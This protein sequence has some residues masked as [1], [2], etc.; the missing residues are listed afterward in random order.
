V[1]LYFNQSGNGWSAA[2]TL[3]CFPHTDNLSA[4]TAVDLLGNGTACLVWSSPL[5]GD[6]RQPMRYIDLM[7]GQKPHLLVKSINNL[8]A[9]TIVQY[10]PSTKFHLDDKRK[11][12]PW[13]TKIPFPVH[14]VERVEIYDWIS[15]NRFVTRY[16]YHHGYYDG[17]EREFRGFGMVEQWDTEELGV[18]TESGELPPTTNEEPA[19]H[20]PPVLTKTWFHTGAY[21]GG[22]RISK[23]FEHEYY[24]EGDPSRSEGLLSDEQLEAMLLEDTI[25]P[26]VILSPDEL[27]EACR[28]L[29][30]SIL[31]QEIYALDRQLD[32]S[33]TEE[34]D[35]PYS[36][37]E[38][39]YTIKRV[40]PQVS[41][42]H[43]V[44]F[45]H[46]RETID[47]LYERKL[48]P[49]L[50]GKVVD[51]ATAADNSDVKR[52]ADPRV[53]HSFTL[54]V[55]KYGNV[56]Q[57]MAVGYGRRYDDAALD[58]EDRAKQKKTLITY[59]ENQYTNAIG[60]KTEEQDVHRTPLP[61]E[62]RTFELVNVTPLSGPAGITKLFRFDELQPLVNGEQFSRGDWD[63][64]YQDVNHTQATEDHAYRRL[65]E[66]VRTLYRRN[67]L[68]GAL[69]LKEVESLA[70]PYESYKLGFTPGLLDQV[71]VRGGQKLLPANA[72]EVLNVEGAVADRG[73]YVDLEGNGLWWVPSGRIFYSH[74]PDDSPS[75]ELAHAQEH[76]FLPHRYRDPFHTN[77]VSTESFVSYDA[78]D[79]LVE[80]TR[81]ALDNQ[82]T[83]GQRQWVLADGTVVPGKGGNDYRVLQPMRV[84]DPNGNC[85][86]VAF[87]ALG[88]V[89]G[90]AVMGK[91]EQNPDERQGDSF[92][93]ESF[94]AD[95]T[96][97]QIHT[98]LAVEDPH[99]LAP[100]LL[101]GATTRII[102]DLDRFRTAKQPVYAATLARETHMSDQ[103]PPDG[104][105]IQISFSYSDGFG[106]EI[107]KKIQA[108]PGPLDLDDPTSPIVAPRWVGSGWTIYN[109]KGKPVQK[110]EPFFDDTLDFKFGKKV[111]VSSTLFYDP[112]E[113]V[114]A[115]LH[116]NDT[117]EKVIFDPWRQTT[118]DANDTVA[119]HGK[120]TGDP[121]T[122][123]DIQGYVVEYFKIQPAT[124][125]TWYQACIAGTKGTEEQ[126]AAQKA[127]KHANTPTV[128]HFDTLGRTFL[129]IAHNRFDREMPGGSVE[130]ADE[131][132]PTRV[133]LDIEG[134]QRTITDALGHIVMRYDYDMLGNR[135]HQVSVDAGARWMLNDVAGNPI[136]AWDSRD[137]SF[138]TEYDPLHR[139][140]RYFV[141]GADPENP[142][143]ELL[144]E[145]LVYGEQHPEAELRNLR[146]KLYVHLDQ[147]GSVTT[148]AHD[149][150]GNLLEASRRL[151]N[152][153]QYRQVVDW[154]PVDA[155][156]VALP[157]DAK[158]LL[159]PAALEAALAPRLEADAYT[160]RT[161]Y[162]ALNR[163]VTLIMPDNTVIRHAY[164]E[165]NLL[166]RVEASLH[167]ATAATPFVTD[168]AYDAKGQSQRIDYGNGVSTF[169]EYDP[170]TFRLVHL[171]TRRNAANFPDDC[172]QSPPAGWPGCQVQNLHYTYD[173]VGNITHIC[174]DA[175]QTVYFKN[176]RIEPSNDY[177][178]DALYR[179]IKAAGREHLG[180]IDGQPNP[181]TEPD[182]FNSFHTNH[183]QPG[184]GKAMGTYVEQYAYDA[185]G[186]ILFMR[187]RG[188][189][190]AHPGWKRCYRYDIGSNRLLDTGKPA[191]LL[192][193]DSPCPSHYV[194]PPI[195]PGPYDYD[196][197]GNMTRMPHLPLMQWD[198]RDQLQA[199]AQ[200][201]VNNGGKPETTW[202]VY[203]ASGQRVRKVTES[204]TTGGQKPVRT[205]ERIYLGGFE[206]Y[207]EYE[208]DGETVTL[209]RE[210][211]RIM[212][213]KQRIA[214]VETRT[215]GND[216]SPGKLIRYQFG[217]HL[218]ST[219]LELDEAARVISYEEYYPYGSTSYQAV[220]K[221]IKVVAKR[222]RY[223]GKERD[224]ETGLYYHGARYYA[225]R[226]GRWISCDPANHLDRPN[227]Y[228][229][230]NA[231]PMRFIDP[232]GKDEKD[233]TKPVAQRQTAATANI[234]V[235]SPG[236]AS[237]STPYT[238][239]PRRT[240]PPPIVP[241][242]PVHE[243]FWSAYIREFNS[244]SSTTNPP[245][246]IPGTEGTLSAILGLPP[247]PSTDASKKLETGAEKVAE[248]LADPMK[249]PVVK[250]RLEEPVKEHWPAAL[251]AVPALFAWRVGKAL[252]DPAIV[253]TGYRLDPVLH[254][255]QPVQ[256]ST[257]NWSKLQTLGTVA[258][259]LLPD[260]NLGGNLSLAF[261]KPSDAPIQNQS[262]R[263]AIA[264][265]LT[266]KLL[267][268]P[269]GISAAGGE[270]NLLYIS[271]KGYVDWRP[272]PGNAS[273]PEA[274]N[275]APEPPLR[276]TFMLNLKL[277]F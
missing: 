44:F 249:N 47:F 152:G 127:A 32:G 116:P 137:H 229:Y 84:M 143:Q 220:D 34:S 94:E 110:Y 179:L 63:I 104:L 242:K 138:R 151:T 62:T 189:D 134:N 273:N 225:A 216:D 56:E 160:S 131:I 140:L 190:P 164:N 168:I 208:N 41:N 112:V 175:Q 22:D 262:D 203:D 252:S 223:T 123:Q 57:A 193:P 178:Y 4:V 198:Y 159:D 6:Q 194:T 76:F 235:P 51:E 13:I 253:T 204:Q 247:D 103:P 72:A 129:T 263:F 268:N 206:L 205:K 120:E 238:L 33:F 232:D 11:G 107:Q 226:L 169:Y 240:A 142:N 37:S 27:R 141:I 133:C 243:S 166:E 96:Q 207:R 95:L 106:R 176:Q 61:S 85:T 217:N 58:E 28:S 79:L 163:P 183:D 26:E 272:F 277:N 82:V 145:R 174:D 154:S 8:G 89:V 80:K 97:A 93:R 170:L 74:E 210:T 113:R 53:T 46:P 257:A 31:R 219:S 213:D 77:T 136:R 45:T 3:Q 42:Q 73:G 270:S 165:A 171:L 259:A 86:T 184:D 10:A 155:D 241:P 248:A 117:Y 2:T 153:T 105:K 39:N 48:F 228:L 19:T 122:D 146:G 261:T 101:K 211:L 126:T 233:R 111:G 83:V 128:T 135:I 191:D 246:S 88:M 214:L 78:Y 244:R 119:E 59:T 231:N 167:G 201:V 254:S 23:Q 81:D 15:R 227:L 199:T 234:S 7:G 222:Y 130:P 67:N 172:P 275:P 114:I 276:G 264:P 25:L 200:G 192:N 260:I 180:Q 18:F 182:A 52:N 202:Y 236:T 118:F 156:Q 65:I 149:F 69:G 75:K 144:T 14:V 161:T 60:E 30:G 71:Y 148:E 150:K 43:A 132:Y 90:T 29:K 218:G 197:H 115:T 50:G 237:P 187:H 230:V 250:Q 139:P 269:P 92:E 100:S 271:V 188:S 1:Y 108:E 267:P 64:P 99:A 49:V 274:T 68:S 66:Q 98:F 196:A 20:V 125:Q 36:V 239:D 87:D 55:D 255:L 251:L 12:K 70:L 212:D 21:L 124:W 157:K 5:A 24:H 38:R 17:I 158:A 91:P 185:V 215:L 258:Y 162:D 102:Y 35:R 9:E 16:A 265:A 245:P 186:N 109:N 40:Q 54:S 181:P 147:A 256:S 221:N 195:Y 266:L 173:P 121:R 209:E 224:E 177:T